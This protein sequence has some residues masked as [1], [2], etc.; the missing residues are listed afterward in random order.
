M[1]REGFKMITCQIITTPGFFLAAYYKKGFTS[2]MLSDR[3]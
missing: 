2:H 3:F 1:R